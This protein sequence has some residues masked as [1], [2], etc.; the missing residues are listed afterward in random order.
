MNE[1]CLA[2]VLVKPDS[3]TS[4]MT[5]TLD[6]GEVQNLP[7]G[8]LRLLDS[9]Y[10]LDG[11]GNTAG[12]VTMVEREE[13]DFLPTPAGPV[14]HI[15]YSEKIPGKFW[16][17]PSAASGEKIMLLCSVVPNPVSD[18]DNAFP[19]SPKYSIPVVEY[20]LYLIFR[21]DSE[22][23]PNAARAQQHRQ[24][25]FDLLQVKNSSDALVSAEAKRMSGM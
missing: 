22:R 12:Y 15:A 18:K 11:S 2:T 3:S 23:S 24:A 8:A 14:R 13:F 17:S 25:F 4:F 19:L 5:A 16:V 20:M 21:R 9:Y 7:E 1:S 6:A 10:R